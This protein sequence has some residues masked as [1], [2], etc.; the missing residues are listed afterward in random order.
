MKEKVESK[1]ILRTATDEEIM[2]LPAKLIEE[3]DALIFVREKIKDFGLDMQIIDVEFQ[4]DSHKLS[5]YYESDHRIDFKA[6]MSTLFSQFKTRI[7]MQRINDLSNFDVNLY[8]HSLAACD[9]LKP[10]TD[11]FTSTGCEK[12]IQEKISRA[13]NSYDTL[14]TAS[15]A[16]SFTHGSV[17]GYND[18]ED[19]TDDDDDDDDDDHN[20]IF[21]S[22]AQ[23]SLAQFT[24]SDGTAIEANVT[25]AY[26]AV[27]SEVNAQADTGETV[28]VGGD[29]VNTNVAGN[30]TVTYSSTDASGNQSIGTQTVT[31]QEQLR[32][33]VDK[34]V[35]NDIHAYEIQ[36][37]GVLH[38]N[39]DLVDRYYE[40]YTDEKESDPINTPIELE[41]FN[42]DVFNP[43]YDYFTELSNAILNG[44]Y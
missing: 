25:L 6:F 27:Y 4:F 12:H 40:A 14:P 28:I 43:D 9:V 18:N 2:A 16:S 31:V 34:V 41:D 23:L 30:H 17:I 5:I 19:D 35:V 44:V 13:C 26:D 29:T 38:L 21:L 8:D 32:P 39:D 37:A 22:L 3:N 10:F 42:F 15:F 7:W 33:I 20:S 1:K 36:P 24:K 11:T